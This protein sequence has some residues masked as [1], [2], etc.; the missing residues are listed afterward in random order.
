MDSHYRNM[1]ATHGAN[2]EIFQNFIAGGVGGTCC[3]ISGHPFDTIKVRLQ[4]MT[5]I[6][7][8]KAPIYT[9]ALDCLKQMIVREGFF[10]LYK[11]MAAPVLGVSPLFAIY[12]GGCSFGRW[13]QQ[14][15]P[16]QEMTIFQNFLSGSLAGMFTTII[17]VPGERIKC[18]LQ[19]QHSCSSNSSFAHYKGP[20]DVVKTLYKEGGVSSIYRGTMAT[21]LRDIPSSGIYL[22]TYEYLKKLFTGDDKTKKLSVMSTL[23]AGGF[24]GIA[25]WSLCIPADVLKSRLQTAPEG[26]YPKGIRSVFKETMQE[27]GPRALF[28]GFTPVMARAFPA[29]AACFLGFEMALSCFQYLET[30]S[31]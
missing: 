5:G 8:G 17:M 22:A 20:V 2:Y 1:S 7:S 12:F 18:L 25:N 4:T 9:G 24:A 27:E 21:L 14:N 10:S 31:L 23:M 15:S 26:K 19:V 30:S 6:P 28:R 11:G 3:V 13:L 29:N 16:D